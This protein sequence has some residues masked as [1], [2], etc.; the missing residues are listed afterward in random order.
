MPYTTEKKKLGHVALK[1]SAKLL[2]CQKEMMHFWYERGLSINAI[3]RM[4]HCN[5]RL[6]HF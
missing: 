2:P 4:F 6:V 1:R 5:K 3:A